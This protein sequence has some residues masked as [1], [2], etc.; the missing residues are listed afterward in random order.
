MLHTDPVVDR[1]MRA[2]LGAGSHFWD[3]DSMRFHKSRPVCGVTNSAGDFAWIVE[4]YRTAYL[5]SVCVQT[6]HSRVIRVNLVT[7]D[8]D[9]LNSHGDRYRSGGEEERAYRTNAQALK[10]ARRF[11]AEYTPALESEGVES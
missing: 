11:A 5:G 1:A 9:V 2:V 8:L 3:P 10:A 7:G 6:P 4:R